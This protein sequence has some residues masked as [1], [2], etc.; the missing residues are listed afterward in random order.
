[1]R[2]D[3]ALI[4]ALAGLALLLAACGRNEDS[5]SAPADPAAPTK[6]PA[7]SLDMDFLNDLQD[8]FDNTTFLPHTISIDRRGGEFTRSIPG[9]PDGAQIRILIP[10]DPTAGD[11]GKSTTSECTILLPAPPADGSFD[12]PGDCLLYKTEN[13]PP[14]NFENLV[15]ALPVLDWNGSAQ[16]AEMF[17]SY[18][19]IED[20]NGNPG[21][22]DLSTLYSRDF[23]PDIGNTRYVYISQPPQSGEP[24]SLTDGVVDPDTIGDE[25]GGSV[26][27]PPDDDED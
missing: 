19:L 22:L 16:Y 5:L 10:D 27:P 6:A 8:A 9:Y 24:S 26:S 2:R 11:D 14:E 25:D 1:M 20:G 18:Q 23:P 3:I 17:T 4:L 12:F 15:L 21:P 13:F 7:Y